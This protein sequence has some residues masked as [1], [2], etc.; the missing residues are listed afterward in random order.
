[1]PTISTQTTEIY[2]IVDSG[3]IEFMST[4]R[5]VTSKYTG[6]TICV[7]FKATCS[8]SNDKNTMTSYN[9]LSEQFM[10]TYIEQL[11]SAGDY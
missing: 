3:E 9:S 8:D 1:M 7:F 4:M 2:K 10:D 6:K 5:T 11:K